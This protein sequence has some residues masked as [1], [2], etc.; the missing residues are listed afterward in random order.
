MLSIS[1]ITEESR[2]KPLPKEI[3]PS[4]NVQP[5]DSLSFLSP[6]L[7]DTFFV[8]YP[9]FDKYQKKIQN[10]YQSINHHYLW[11]SSKGELNSFAKNLSE[12]ADDLENEGLYIKPPYKKELDSLLLHVSKKPLENRT[13]ELLLTSLYYFYI[14]NVFNGIDSSETTKMGWHLP[15]KDKSEIVAIDSVLLNQ[16]LFN[17]FEATKF[18]QY[19]KLKKALANYK[20]IDKKGSWKKIIIPKDFTYL[21]PGDTS[22]LIPQIR[23]RLLYSK[24]VNSKSKSN[25]YDAELAKGIIKYQRR[26]SLKTDGIIRK[27]VIRSM[28]VSV[29]ERI[30]TIEA[31]MERCRWISDDLTQ[32]DNYIFINIP[33]YKLTFIRNKKPELISKVVV[34]KE[35]NQTVVFSGEMNQIVFSPFWYVPNSI[36]QKE[37]IPLI[38]KDSSYLTKNNMEWYEEGRLRQKPGPKNAL[39]QVKFIFPNTNSIYLH[40]TPAKELFNEDKRAFSHG[41]IRVESPKKLALAVLKNDPNWNSKKIDAAMNA[42][43]QKT[44]TLKTKI[45]VYI[46]YFTSWVDDYGNVLF[47]DDIYNQDKLLL[48]ILEKD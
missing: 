27:S 32:S 36:I 20:K 8:K 13:T 16:E 33:A 1:F 30:A 26:N 3:F 29:S 39:G 28:N 31:N 11:L 10:K 41:C 17:K 40:D 45:P 48:K 2:I 44:Y 14:D 7:I 47:F 9:K 12:K 37:I 5:E 6:E 18:S 19:N 22:K 43:I 34:G 35:M 42:G 15:R 21:E 23:K 25:I 4:Q 38:E 24:Y 46:G